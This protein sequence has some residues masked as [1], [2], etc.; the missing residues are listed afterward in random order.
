MATIE[1][2]LN[3]TRIFPPSETFSTQANISSFE[4]YEALC[5]EA[6]SDYEAFGGTALV[7]K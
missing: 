1:S 2:T 4:A 7:S 3:E 5:K 6:E